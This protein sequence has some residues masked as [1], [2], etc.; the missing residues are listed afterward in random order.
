LRDNLRDNTYAYVFSHEGSASYTEIVGGGSEEFYGTCHA[1][2]L[3][4]LFPSHKTIPALFTA[5]PSR[6]DKEVTRLMT[7]L[8][9]NF[10]STG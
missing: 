3:L 8:W 1:D 2:E 4:Y 6:G 5:I 10:A 9:V 7:K